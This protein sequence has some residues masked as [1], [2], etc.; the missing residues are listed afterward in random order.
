[1][2]VS[3]GGGNQEG[4]GAARYG[5][6]LGADGHFRVYGK[7]VDRDHTSTASG[8]RVNDGWYK[9]QAGFRA[10]WSRPRDQV[11]VQGNAYRGLIDQP[12]PGLVSV[13]G[14]TLALGP[15]PVSGVN[16]TGRWAHQLE[17]GS[18]VLLEANFDHT[19]RTVPPTF[20]EKLD[21]FDVQFQHSSTF[22]GYSL[23]WGAESR[24]SIDRVAN[25]AIFA[26]LPANVHQ[27]WSSL[28][29]QGEANLR[30]DL[31]LTVGARLER[32]D[33]TGTEV[34]PSARLGWKLAANHLLWSAISRTVRA[35]SRLDRD[36]FVPG[37]PPFLLDGGRDTRSEVAKVLE[38][39]YR[40][41][42]FGNLSY[43]ATVFHANYDHLHTQEVVN[44]AFIVFSNLMEA[45]TTGV[46]MWGTWQVTSAWRL[47]AGYTAQRET[48][49]LKP[50]SNDAAAVGAARRDPAYTWLARSS[51]NISPN[52]DF[53]VTV[54]GVAGLENPNVP[55]YST[56]DV[57][58]GWRPSPG[59]ELSLA[60]RNLADGG[61]G[62]F[63]DVATRTEVGRSIYASVRW[64]FDAR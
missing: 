57:R 58:L 64:E 53:D 19:E 6:P 47:A 3:A 2:L 50:G 37:T 27:N 59:I 26:F 52:T 39:G 54:R 62:E 49:R 38:I 63:T 23:V 1:V 14:V 4:E 56:M 46:E 34:L 25:S 31:E 42:P 16:L 24:A 9:G 21:I 5:G 15:I 40:G 11:M 13:T 61:H 35:P 29:A 60:A 41:Q 7:Y 18:N 22:S 28:Y 12:L 43:S 32:N 55:A 33:Y 30:E 51:M 10:D 45:T 8:G 48:F 36:A 44:R 17:G 20:G